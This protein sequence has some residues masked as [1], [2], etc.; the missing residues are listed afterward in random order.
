[1]KTLERLNV[2]TGAEVG[3]F[4]NN[5]QGAKD[6]FLYGC[7]Y[8]FSHMLCARFKTAEMMYL[9]IENH[10]VVMIDGRLY[11]ARGDVTE[12]YRVSNIYSWDEYKTFDEL[13]T[14]RIIK[15]CINKTED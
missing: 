10:F 11:D 9:P 5:F 2:D 1:M 13:E 6:T 7:C 8:W 3:R 12:L 14:A 4:I 15:Y